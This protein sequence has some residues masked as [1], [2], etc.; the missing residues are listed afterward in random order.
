MAYLFLIMALLCLTVK[1]YCGK[2]TGCYISGA[3]DPLL[4]NLL[5]MLFCIVIGLGVVFLESAGAQLAV[6]GGMLWI[7]L[8]SGAANA[9][10]LVGWLLAIQ[11]NPMVT[12]DVTLTVGSILPAVLCAIL[13]GEAISPLKMVGFVLI[14][15][16]TAILS[17]YGKSAGKGSGWMGGLLVILAALG[18]GLSS[19]CQQLYKQYYTEAG[20]Q[21]HGAFYPK[22]VYHFYTYAFAA[23]ILLLC[24]AGFAVW[25]YVGLS[26]AEKKGYV[27]RLFAPCKRP[28][29]HI[30]IMAICMFAA[31][32]FQT[33]ATNDY[34]MP[35]Q[36]LYPVIKGGCLITVNITAMLFFGEKPTRRSI[37]GSVIALFGI[38][39]MSIL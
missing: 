12:V 15:A 6:E 35:S 30:I 20:T 32:Y 13:F 21:A 5:R 2:K 38:V 10:F 7:C 23:A 29:P 4:F 3:G 39:A 14:L 25:Q 8:C 31:N 33:V 22:S 16:A 18:D 28:M 36:I 27:C 9:A 26:A 37:T 24:F 1:G 19:F 34:G 17:G 11:K